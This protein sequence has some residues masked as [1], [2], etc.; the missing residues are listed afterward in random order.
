M[1]HK[2]IKE[3]YEPPASLDQARHEIDKKHFSPG[4][5]PGEKFVMAS[6]QKELSPTEFISFASRYASL[7]KAE[8]KSSDCNVCSSKKLNRPC[9]CLPWSSE[10]ACPAPILSRYGEE[11]ANLL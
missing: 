5:L 6:G 11:V 10:V 9:L 1:K 8:G 3:C 2:K 4:D 7:R